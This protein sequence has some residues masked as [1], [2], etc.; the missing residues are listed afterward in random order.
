MQRRRIPSLPVT[1]AAVLAVLP[2]AGARAQP[3]PDST[4]TQSVRAAGMPLADGALSPGSLTVRIVQGAFAGDLVGIAVSLDLDGRDARSAR[5]GAMGRAEFAHLPVGATVRASAVV[6]GERL[7]SD[8]F[9]MPAES[10][11]RIL[12]VTGTG[13]AGTTGSDPH[14]A[15]AGAPAAAP[16]ALASAGTPLHGAT[17]V[18]ATVVSMTVLAFA[19]VGARQWRR[20]RSL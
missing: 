3:L 9:Q 6:N 16:R 14:A 13:T 12:L 7:E 10:G 1:L 8:P 5:T 15:G 11:V 4:A 17:V 20:R 18:R 19:L 2:A